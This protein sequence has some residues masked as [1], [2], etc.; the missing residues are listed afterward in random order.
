MKQLSPDYAV[1]LQAC[2]GERLLID[3][4]DG[5][6]DC[7]RFAPDASGLPV[8]FYCDA[9]GLRPGMFEMARTLADFGHGALMPNLYHRLGD[10]AP[11]DPATV[12]SDPDEHA[13]LMTMAAGLSVAEA[14]R[15]TQACLDYLD[16]AQVGALG[17]CLGG[18][19]AL[20]AAG[21]F[22]TIMAAAS[23]HGGALATDAP[24]SPHRLVAQMPG[25]LYIAVAG[26]DPYFT[27]EEQA[28]LCASLD[29]AGTDYTLA[30]YPEAQHGF[31][32]ADMPVFEPASA[33]RH[34]RQVQ[35]FFQ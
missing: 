19:L 34:W 16:A 25:R 8:I 9:G 1:S 3:S 11:F 27:P 4:A 10:Y 5:A 23:I 31:A 30:L 14:M 18:K 28:R 21:H 7:Y 32:V 24:D 13:R 20:S 15:D 12:F 2:G 17:Y 22:A 35:A 6:M 33:A 26:I 29:Q